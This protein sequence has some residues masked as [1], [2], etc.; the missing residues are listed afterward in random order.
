MTLSRVVAVALALCC[1]QRYRKQ[2]K[3]LSIVA[4]SGLKGGLSLALASTIPHTL[5]GASLVVAMVYAVV[6]F[7]LIVQSSFLTFYLRQVH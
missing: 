3:M 6:A 7:T 1:W 5:P 2:P 4:F